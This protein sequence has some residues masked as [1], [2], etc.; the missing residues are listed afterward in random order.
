LPPGAYEIAVALRNAG[1]NVSFGVD[2][3]V[4]VKE[5]RIVVGTRP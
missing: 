4:P 3:A 5:F 1:I 2:K